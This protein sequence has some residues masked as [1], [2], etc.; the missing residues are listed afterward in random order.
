MAL[1]HSQR[2]RINQLDGLRGLLALY[3]ALFHLS[4]PFVAPGA[5]LQG[6][7]WLLAQAW[8]SVDVFFVMSGF[9]MMHVYGAAFA[10]GWSWP[11]FGRFMWARVARLYP[12]HVAT[13]ALTA[14]GVAR[15][16]WGTPEMTQADGRY[17]WQAA[18]MSLFMLHGPW[19]DHRTWNYPSWSIS[20]EWHAYLV[21]PLAV[22]VV[23]RWRGRAAWTGAVLAACI[24]VG[25][26]LGLD[27]ADTYPTN[28]VWVLAR[29]LPLFLAGMLVR[30]AT[31]R[32]STMS[33]PGPWPWVLVGLTLLML[34]AS[35]WP[36]LSVILIPGL[37][38]GILNDRWLGRFFSRPGMLWLGA[39]SYSLY[40]THALVAMLVTQPALR[41][42]WRHAGRD[43]LMDT[44]LSLLI[45]LASTLLS[46]GLAHLTWACIEVPGRAWLLKAW[47]RT[48]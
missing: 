6:G 2:D 37:V 18:L 24:P 9:V 39:I 32:A 8:Y 7:A 12:V 27:L 3:V 47:R 11:R 43:A 1:L 34:F 13:L 44:R 42:W 36:A 33:G 17:A 45:L 28:G 46:L 41:A 35:A 4:A 25:V 20:A 48:S 15:A 26:Y 31:A 30:Q 19:V 16:Y 22:L 10:Q 40:M 21:F 23:H 38:W 29:V 5:S 14:L